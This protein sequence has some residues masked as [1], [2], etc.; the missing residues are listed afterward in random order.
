MDETD[1]RLLRAMF[2]QMV[3]GGS[4]HPDDLR[5]AALARAVDLSVNAVKA[6][7]AKLEDDGLFQG[8][9]CHPSLAA[10]GLEGGAFLVRAAERR[11]REAALGEIHARGRLLRVY[12]YAG[13]H[14]CVEL[15][16]AGEIEKRDLLDVLARASA[17]APQPWL[18]I[19]GA[20]P[21]RPLSPLDWR[22]LAAMR[23]EPLAS[24]ADAAREVGVSARTVKRHL[25][26]LVE[27]GALW[28]MPKLDFGRASG[29]L[30][31]EMLFT[32]KPGADR[33]GRAAI[34]R[35]FDRERV[36]AFEPASHAVGHFDILAV[37]GST[38][39]AEDLRRR[40][41]ELAEVERVEALFFTGAEDRSGWLDRLIARQGGP[42]APGSVQLRPRNGAQ[43]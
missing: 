8:H 37:A 21:P 43:P 11:A 26:R 28:T 22:V 23:R 27:G 39:E 38:A 1:V 29:R 31:V 5:P 12:A 15:A 42:E 14:L 2:P 7:L 25:D 20:I 30:L 41:E 33:A 13:D 6:R 34:L 10:L 9:V 19:T 40:G 24:P 32:L 4:A 16:Y 17:H 3:G 36:W 18:E 35:A